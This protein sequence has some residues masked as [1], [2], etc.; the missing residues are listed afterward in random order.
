MLHRLLWATVY[1]K[2]GSAT[3]TCAKPLHQNRISNS[4]TTFPPKRHLI[5]LSSLVMSLW[6]TWTHTARIEFTRYVNWGR[7]LWPLRGPI[8][9]TRHQDVCAQKV[10]EQQT[11]RT[12]YG[13]SKQPDATSTL[14]VNTWMALGG[15]TTCNTVDTDSSDSSIHSESLH[16]NKCLFYQKHFKTM[17]VTP[18]DNRLRRKTHFYL[19]LDPLQR[20]TEIVGTTS[21]LQGWKQWCRTP[22]CCN[23]LSSTRRQPLGPRGCS[24]NSE[25][26]LCVKLQ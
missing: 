25:K 5:R 1:P 9:R 4:S 12:W 26:S 18:L 3:Q 13:S 22:L 20:F 21:W 17:C 23:L 8:S 14:L 2:E 24:G 19:Y 16:P 10:R 11:P 7:G 15:C 6:D